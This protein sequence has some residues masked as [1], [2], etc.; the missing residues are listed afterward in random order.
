MYN[1]YN[2]I[3]IHIKLNY[4]LVIR[5][6]N[7]NSYNFLLTTGYNYSLV[8]RLISLLRNIWYIVTKIYKK[9]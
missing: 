9:L 4:S 5:T 1:I 7:I 8:I 6:S 3:Y 2:Q